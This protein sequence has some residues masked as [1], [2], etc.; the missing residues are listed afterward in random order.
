MTFIDVEPLDNIDAKIVI[1]LKILKRFKYCG[2]M[3]FWKC[4]QKMKKKP[5]RSSTVEE[6][7]IVGTTPL[8]FLLYVSKSILF[9]N[10]GSYFS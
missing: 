7:A 10:I 1:I 5:I 6:I 4:M 9:V 3:Q 8:F 2:M